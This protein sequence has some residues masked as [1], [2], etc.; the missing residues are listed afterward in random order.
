MYSDNIFFC[1]IFLHSIHAFLRC[2]DL[3]FSYQS[4]VEPARRNIRFSF[5]VCAHT[6]VKRKGKNVSQKAENEKK[7]IEQFRLLPFCHAGF[8]NAAYVKIVCR[9]IKT[10]IFSQAQISPLTLLFLSKSGKV[11]RESYYAFHLKFL[12]FFLLAFFYVRLMAGKFICTRLLSQ[13]QW[14]TR[15]FF[16]FTHFGVF[17][18]QPPLIYQFLLCFLVEVYFHPAFGAS[19]EGEGGSITNNYL[20][21]ALIWARFPH[22]SWLIR[23]SG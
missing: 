1:S 2:Q 16:F 9:W 20:I 12:R 6:V 11:N 22:L 13:H 15:R 5:I 3:R 21:T 14:W 23:N 7:K 4:T 17:C 8:D 19:E 10:R 18:A